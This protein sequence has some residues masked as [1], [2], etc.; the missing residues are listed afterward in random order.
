[1]D[2]L[3]LYQ[4][5]PEGKSTTENAEEG[6]FRGHW[7]EDEDEDTDDDNTSLRTSE[8]YGDE[9]LDCTAQTRKGPRDAR[10]DLDHEIERLIYKNG[11][12]FDGKADIQ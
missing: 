12:V 4:M 1:M 11:L 7:Y 9:H 2:E 5:Q 6:L 3:I 8:D 10:T